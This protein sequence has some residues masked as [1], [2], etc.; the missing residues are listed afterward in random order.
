M[1][2]AAARKPHTAAPAIRPE[3]KTENRHVTAFSR[4]ELC[5]R[6]N[7]YL[8]QG[9]ATLLRLE[10]APDALRR[11]RHQNKSGL[12]QLTTEGGLLPSSSAPDVYISS[13]HFASILQ[14]GI[15]AIASITPLQEKEIRLE[16]LGSGAMRLTLECESVN[17]KLSGSGAF[18]LSGITDRFDAEMSGPGDLKASDLIARE[19]NL[20]SSGSGKAQVA[21]VG[22]LNATING[23]G[24]V[25][26]RDYP[27][28]NLKSNGSGSLKNEN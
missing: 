23:S 7:V 16:I 25:G 12:L 13:P 9:G 19:V 20:V 21:S 11:I 26:Y 18:A 14:K 15:G 3:M 17:A 22:L 6:G 8:V 24:N 2:E 1:P 5:I 27:V 10:G 4:L 28:I